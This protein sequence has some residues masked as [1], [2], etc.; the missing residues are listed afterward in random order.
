MRAILERRSVRRYTSTPISKQAIDQL[1]D[2]AIWAPSGS[3]AQTWRFVVVRDAGR[4]R[5]LRIVSPGL[6][7]PPPCV[8]VIS[9]DMRKASERGRRLGI[10]RLVYFDSAMAAQNIMLAAHDLGLGSCVVASFHGK[11][12][13]GLLALPRDVK[14]ILLVALGWP[15]EQP[16]ALPRLRKEV[17]FNERYGIPY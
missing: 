3:N 1:L 11:A 7:G 5:D 6:P 15:A 14:P 2:A 8:L 4:I 10:E 17:L 12:V 9:Q 16:L 13:Q